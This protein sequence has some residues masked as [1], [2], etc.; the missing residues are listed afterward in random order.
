MST[1]LPAIVAASVR[2]DKRRLVVDQHRAGA[3]FAA[4][5]AGLG[6]G[7]ADLLAQVVE[8]Q[9]I[10]GDRI[11]AVAPVEPAFKQPGQTFL[12]LC[13]FPWRRLFSRAVIVVA[14]RY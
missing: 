4:V 5:A 11:G 3:A 1:R 14:L 8:Q 13:L 7:Q 9:D 6:A 12:P 2:Q 10:V